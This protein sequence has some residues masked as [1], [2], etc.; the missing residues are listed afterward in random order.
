MRF[1]RENLHTAYRLPPTRATVYRCLWH[2]CGTEP[3]ARE[4][5]PDDDLFHEPE[6]QPNCVTTGVPSRDHATWP[7]PV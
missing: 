4:Q 1:H 2:V 6:T 3:S 5:N 7:P